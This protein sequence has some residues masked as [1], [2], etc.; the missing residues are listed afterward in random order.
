MISRI[1]VPSGGQGDFFASFP[2][3][4]C[5][6]V[7]NSIITGIAVLVKEILCEKQEKHP[8]DAS[9]VCLL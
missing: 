6:V 7:Y 3:A 2:F 4:A 9:P 1:T 8:A 5:F